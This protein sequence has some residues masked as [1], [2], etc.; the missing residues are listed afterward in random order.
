MPVR[1]VSREAISQP[2]GAP[3]LNHANPLA[4]KASAVAVPT[5][6][7]MTSLSARK[8]VDERADPSGT[9]IGT[10]PGPLGLGVGIAPGGSLTTDALRLSATGNRTDTAWEEPSSAVTWMAVCV[11]WGNNAN[12]N[13][14]IFGNFTAS[15]SP[16][17]A[18]AVNDSTG[19]GNL[20]FE[21]TTGGTAK[22]ATQ[23]GGLTN[24]TPLVLIGRYDGANLTGWKNGVQVAST[25]ATGTI[26]YASHSTRGPA[27]GNL[28]NFTASAR[29]FNGRVFLVAVWP[30]ALSDDEIRQLSGNP[31]QL[32]EDDFVFPYAAGGGAAA[33]SA[34]AQAVASLTGALST[35]ISLAASPQAISTVSA[36]LS[37]QIALAGSA[38]AQST[39]TS[40]LTTA[41]RLAASAQS[42]ATL[43]GTLTSGTAG[44]QLQAS[45]S[46]Q[47]SLTASLSTAITLAAASSATATLQGALTTQ[48]RLAAAAIGTASLQGNLTAGVVVV[49]PTPASR[50]LLVPADSRRLGMRADDRR[51]T[52]AFDD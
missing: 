17:T 1:I 34:T 46:A 32:L 31:W 21:I 44:A 51:F 41:I 37:T 30:V 24:N 25:A 47:S 38:V 42:I 4:V 7:G 3:R 26:G 28:Y 2:T 23:T 15:V 8:Y 49:T 27:V 11:R 39:L 16:G 18:W 48:I 33:L 45:A 9:G 50:R 52:I 36:A 14:F 29:S 19:G 22:T 40:S 43:T 10:G 6:G 5:G 20:Q 12:G 35:Q 13:A